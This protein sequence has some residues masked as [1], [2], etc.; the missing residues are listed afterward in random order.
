MSSIYGIL[1]RESRTVTLGDDEKLDC[2]INVGSVKD[3]E[4]FVKVWVG[5]DKAGFNAEMNIYCN[6]RGL[7]LFASTEDDSVIVKSMVLELKDWLEECDYEDMFGLL[8]E[9]KELEATLSSYLEDISRVE[10]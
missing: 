8:E 7:E 2:S 1:E 9:L 6:K 4:E 3:S 10:E 5:K